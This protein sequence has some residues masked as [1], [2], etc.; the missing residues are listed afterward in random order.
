MGHFKIFMKWISETINRRLK[1]GYIFF[2]IVLSPIG[3]RRPCV[4]QF[5]YVSRLHTYEWQTTSIF[6]PTLK[7]KRS[8]LKEGAHD[9]IHKARNC[10]VLTM[11]TSKA[12][13]EHILKTVAGVKKW[14]LRSNRITDQIRSWC[15]L[16]FLTQEKKSIKIFWV[17]KWMHV[18]Q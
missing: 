10:K 12:R 4:H 5:L 17:N 14:S 7:Q 11:W 15:N 16:W 18:H 13:V 9:E 3:Q 1:E 6:Y 8:P 2:S